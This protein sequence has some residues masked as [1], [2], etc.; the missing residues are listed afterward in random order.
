MVIKTGF[1]LLE[2]S[3]AEQRLHDGFLLWLEYS[4]AGGAGIPV[5]DGFVTV[6]HSTEYAEKDENCESYHAAA[7]RLIEQQVGCSSIV[8]LIG[9][10]RPLYCDAVPSFYS[11]SS[12]VPA[13]A[14]ANGAFCCSVVSS[15]QISLAIIQSHTCKVNLS[16]TFHDAGVLHLVQTGTDM[17]SGGE[18][19]R[20]S[21]SWCAPTWWSFCPINIIRVS[22]GK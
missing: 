4:G 3:Q 9:Y 7:R 10:L 13:H 21:H 19:Y 22:F 18:E 1:V 14:A 15:A 6:G 2:G 8:I 11:P 20:N 12:G 16:A 17:V 5:G